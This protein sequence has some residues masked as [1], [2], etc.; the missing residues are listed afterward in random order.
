MITVLLFAHLRE[1]VGEEKITLSLEGTVLDVKQALMATYPQLQLESVMTAVNE[2]FSTDK[3]EVKNGDTIA[4]IP[5][6]S[7]G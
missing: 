4:F 6:I 5:P 1:T 2:Q 3:S 7:G